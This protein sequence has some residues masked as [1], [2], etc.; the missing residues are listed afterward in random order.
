MTSSRLIALAATLTTCFSATLASDG[1][2]VHG[3]VVRENRRPVRSVVVAAVEDPSGWSFDTQKVHQRGL[4]DASGRFRFTIPS[5][6]LRRTRLV[7]V[8]KINRS[9]R[10]DGTIVYSGTSVTLERPISVTAA[11]VIVVPNDFVPAPETASSPKSAIT[12]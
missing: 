3:S 8:G 7:A 5:R 6:A 9:H 1:V 12:P 2:Q 4:T 10:A 11:N